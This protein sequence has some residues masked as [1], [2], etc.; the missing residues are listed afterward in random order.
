MH[1]PIFSADWFS[2]NIPI[3][4]R[5]VSPHLLATATPNV[6]EIGA[7]EGRSSLWF[8][9]NF[10]Q[11]TLTVIDP[12]NFT[13]SATDETY[14]RFKS[15]IEP[16]TAR[17]TIHRDKSEFARSLKSNQFDAIYID[18]EHTSA[19]VLH[20]AIICFELLKAGGLLIF[21]DYLGGDRSIMYPK[22]AIDFFG[23]AYGALKKVELVSDNYQR[24]YRKLEGITPPN[25]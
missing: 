3:W 23:E 1:R 22:P 13:A 14:D 16:Y 7:F 5:I 8:L 24:I 18:G 17:V 21:D 9:E 11:L 25:F 2:H 20:D 10:P 6:L 15:N 19:A 4:E 12:W